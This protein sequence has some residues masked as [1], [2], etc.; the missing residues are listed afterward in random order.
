[1]HTK[2]YYLQSERNRAIKWSFT[3][4]VFSAAFSLD[5]L[6]FVYFIVACIF[7]KIYSFLPV[8]FLLN[9]SKSTLVTK[10]CLNVH[11]SF[12]HCS[13]VYFHHPLHWTILPAK[14]DDMFFPPSTSCRKPH[15]K[16]LWAESLT[17]LGKEK[18]ELKKKKKKK[19]WKTTSHWLPHLSVR[20]KSW[21]Q[22]SRAT[23]LPEERRVK[24]GHLQQGDCHC[25]S[26][27]LTYCDNGRRRSHKS[28]VRGRWLLVGL[29]REPQDGKGFALI[30]R[31]VW[32]L[33]RAW[34]EPP[35]NAGFKG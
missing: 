19:R 1:M 7:K 27:A 31:A 13:A 4:E 16:I 26:V 12:W 34:G 29:L 33:A 30:L 5:A 21:H 28:D 18:G 22:R 8:I 6:C 25:L 15:L 17:T 23:H 20:R 2:C 24:R 14:N 9:Y 35:R 11:V 10:L 32:T 3:V